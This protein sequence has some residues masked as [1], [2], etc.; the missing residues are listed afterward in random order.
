MNSNSGGLFG[1]SV[2]VVEDEYMIADDVARE[3]RQAGANVIGPAASLP[4][5][6]RL[7]AQT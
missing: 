3:L 4:Q 2:L 5:A 1:K 6:M 7:I